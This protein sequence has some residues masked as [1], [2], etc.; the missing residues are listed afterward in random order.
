[1]DRNGPINT[2][3]RSGNRYRVKLRVMIVYLFN[4]EEVMDLCFYLGTG[5]DRLAGRGLDGKVREL[6]LQMGRE[7]RILELIDVCKEKRPRANWEELIVAAKEHAAVFEKFEFEPH[8]SE[9][10]GAGIVE[11][12]SLMRDPVVRDQVVAFHKDFE[13]IQEEIAEIKYFKKLHDAF[14]DIE[15]GYRLLAQDRERLTEDETAWDDLV[16]NE[17]PLQDAIFDLLEKAQNP[18]PKIQVGP[19]V[20]LLS[21]SQGTLQQAVLDRNRRVLESG[22]GLVFRAADRGLPQVNARLVDAAADLPLSSLVG[23]LTALHENVAVQETPG[24]GS[25]DRFAEGIDA[26]ADLTDSL[27]TLVIDHN[28]WQGLDDELRRIEANIADDIFELELSW[29]DVTGMA[30]RLYGAKDER[31]A[32]SLRAIA[33]LLD[34]ALETK[35]PTTIAI[36]DRYRSQVGRRFRQVDD[37]LLEICQELS[38]IGRPINLLLEAIR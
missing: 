20:N 27:A 3:K 18:P 38:N 33:Q 12:V 34:S 16:I 6:I 32:G 35:P 31:W 19:W 10:A 37:D 22:L 11:L 25:I 2:T 14:Q 4:Q 21:K 24:S 8:H 13:F 7:Q 5:Y 29:P 28:E 1:M 23:E 9:S 17:I 36:F 26:L 30:D 15:T